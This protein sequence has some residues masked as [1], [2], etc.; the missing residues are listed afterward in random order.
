MIRKKN[1]TFWLLLTVLFIASCSGKEPQKGAKSKVKILIEG[2]LF[3]PLY[4]SHILESPTFVGPIWNIESC[5]QNRIKKIS[6][7]V[8]GGNL[9]NQMNEKLTYQFNTKGQPIDFHHYLYQL[10]TEPFS[11]STFQYSGKNVLK[12][13]DISKFMNISNVPPYFFSTDSI[14]VFSTT[15]KGNGSFDSTFFY[16]TIQQP[17]VILEVVNQFKSTLEIIVDKGTNHSDIQEIVA[18][19]DTTKNAF[20]LTEKTITYTE[21]G[22]PIE[23]YHVDN[24]WNKIEKSKSWTYNAVGLLTMYCEWL[25]G[26]RIKIIEVMYKENQTPNYLLVDRKKYFFYLATY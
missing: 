21:K 22:L 13:I 3:N 6:L 25:H 15:S 14:S 11:F 5:A 26:T 19:I 1:S 18:Q 17:K 23:S 9:P 20:D 16:P 7:Y 8:K 10:T 2:N 24:N 4:I 12:Q